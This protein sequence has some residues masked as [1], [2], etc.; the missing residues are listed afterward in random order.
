[1]FSSGGEPKLPFPKKLAS[2]LRDRNTSLFLCAGGMTTIH[3]Q[4]G[5]LTMWG[6]NSECKNRALTLRD[7][8]SSHCEEE[9]GDRF[10]LLA[11]LSRP[12]L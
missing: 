10:T 9:M 1:M 12:L 2:V 7:G 5:H 11:Q 3:D 6:H 8:N 4:M